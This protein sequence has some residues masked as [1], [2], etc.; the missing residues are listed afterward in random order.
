MYFQE[1]FNKVILINMSQQVG[2]LR[3]KVDTSSTLEGFISLQDNQELR[4]YKAMEIHRT[5]LT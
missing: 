4:T 1:S 2:N 3:P 5:D